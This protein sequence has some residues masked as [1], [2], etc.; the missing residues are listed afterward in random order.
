MILGDNS[1]W[2][3]LSVS[4]NFAPA[5]IYSIIKLEL[6]VTELYNIK[7]GAIILQRLNF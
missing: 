7:I 2:G 5:V 6:T 3:A 4:F 1:K